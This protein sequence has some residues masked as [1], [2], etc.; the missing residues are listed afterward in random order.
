MTPI[1][2]QRPHRGKKL[3][4]GAVSLISSH[5]SSRKSLWF[6][7]AESMHWKN[8]A[9]N[10]KIP[11]TPVLLGCI[12]W[13]SI[14]NFG[15]GA[16]IC[17]KIGRETHLEVPIWEHLFCVLDPRHIEYA[18]ENKVYSFFWS[19]VYI[20]ASFSR[21]YITLQH[22]EVLEMLTN[23]CTLSIWVLLWLKMEI[24][25]EPGCEGFPTLWVNFVG[26]F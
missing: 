8:L 20:S 19:W 6:Q 21:C 1:W 9:L 15:V 7:N 17:T 4:K 12:L 18:P 3:L 14:E 10:P 16:S 2:G 24:S 22:V 13:F 26:F 5:R 25:F 11:L 23:C